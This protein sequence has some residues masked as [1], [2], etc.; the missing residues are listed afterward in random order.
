MKPNN[1]NGQGVGV[2]GFWAAPAVEICLPLGGVVP[3]RSIERFRFSALQESSK[4][5]QLYIA[6]C[7]SLQRH[8]MLIESPRAQKHQKR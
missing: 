4:P 6:A 2:E 3:F 8:G 5:Q 1:D 7:P